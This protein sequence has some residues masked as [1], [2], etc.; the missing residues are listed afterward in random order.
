MLMMCVA[1]VLQVDGEMHWT[2]GVGVV[3][4]HNPPPKRGGGPDNTIHVSLECRRTAAM[5]AL[6]VDAGIVEPQRPWWRAGPNVPSPAPPPPLP[7]PGFRLHHREPPKESTCL[8]P[9]MC[10]CGFYWCA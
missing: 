1:C 4:P 6:G 9:W 5:L 10:G 7:H 8:W 2:V 3:Y